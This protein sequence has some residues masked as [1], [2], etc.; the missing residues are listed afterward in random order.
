[1]ARRVNERLEQHRNGAARPRC[2]VRVG[3]SEPAILIADW[4]GGAAP[5]S[6]F[7]AVA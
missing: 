6:S 5:A 2:H 1:M 4:S 7:A 3:R